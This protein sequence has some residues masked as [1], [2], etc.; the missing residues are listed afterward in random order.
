MAGSSPYDEAAIE[1]LACLMQM[2]DDA[3]KAFIEAEKR[4]EEGEEGAELYTLVGSLKSQALELIKKEIKSLQAGIPGVQQLSAAVI[5][6]EAE[7]RSKQRQQEQQQE[8]QNQA[9]EDTKVTIQLKSP[10]ASGTAL[11]SD[12]GS[13]TETDAASAGLLGQNLNGDNAADAVS[14]MT[15]D[16]FDPEKEALKNEVTTMKRKEVIMQ[17]D[18]ATM[19]K[20]MT[21]MKKKMESMQSS[22]G[23]SQEA[24]SR[25]A[26]LRGE[27]VR[28][29]GDDD[30]GS[31]EEEGRDIGDNEAGGDGNEGWT[32][33]E[34]D[35][36]DDNKERE[37]SQ[38]CSVLCFADINLFTYVLRNALYPHKVRID[39]LA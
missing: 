13:A 2:K 33:D 37:V 28:A 35:R 12:D 39:G 5:Y 26:Q 25:M 20:K 18:M 16:T 6:T 1:R 3:K 10:A 11:V 4:K 34:S 9:A 24:Q 32:Q 30:G 17:R 23:I 7:E 15:V 27:T 29:T 36:N 22:G 38:Y 19:T 14:P 31:G 8:Q 21:A